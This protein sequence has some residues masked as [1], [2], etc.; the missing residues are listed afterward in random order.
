MRDKSINYAFKRSD[1][2]ISVISKTC[3]ND[4]MTF[5]DR[6]V[7]RCKMNNVKVVL[8]SI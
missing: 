1:C 6:R 3:F 2:G 4:E 8:E 5:F 7:C